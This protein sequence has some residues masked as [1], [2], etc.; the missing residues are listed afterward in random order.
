MEFCFTSC[1]QSSSVPGGMSPMPAPS[2][3]R[4]YTCA[5]D[6]PSTWNLQARQSYM[7][8]AETGNL[9]V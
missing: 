3:S 6:S 7:G 1:A 9:G 8:M 4:R 5:D 2:G